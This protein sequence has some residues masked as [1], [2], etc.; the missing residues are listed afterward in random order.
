MQIRITSVLSP[1][2]VKLWDQGHFAM[3]FHLNEGKEERER[4]KKETWQNANKL[5]NLKCN[6]GLF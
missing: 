3:G 5:L 2:S 4:E 1:S 6:G